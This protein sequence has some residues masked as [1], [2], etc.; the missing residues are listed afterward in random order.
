MTK[1]EISVSEKILKW[2]L[3]KLMEKESSTN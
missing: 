3:S 2:W 1:M